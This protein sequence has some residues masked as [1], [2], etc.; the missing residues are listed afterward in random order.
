LALALT[1]LSVTIL[2][3]PVAQAATDTVTNCSGDLLVPG[4]LP[5]EVANADPG[6]TVAFSLSP[7][8]ATITPS[9]TIEL[10]EDLTI[11]GPGAGSLTVSGGGSI[12]VL[13]VDPGVTASISGLSIDNGIASGGGAIINQGSLMVTGSILSNDDASIGEGGAVYNVTG[14]T[15]SISDSTLSNDDASAGGGIFNDGATL[16]VTDSTLSNDDAS[17]GGGVYNDNGG[18]VSIT[19]STLAN[20]SAGQTGGGLDNDNFGVLTLTSSTLWADGADIEGGGFF[21]GEATMTIGSIIVAASPAGGDCSWNVA[22]TDEGDNLGDD[23]SCLFHAATDLFDTPAGLYPELEDNGGPTQTVALTTGS[24][25]IHQV[26]NG[27]LCPG[28][29]QRGAPR[30]VPCDIGAYEGSVAPPVVPVVSDVSPATGFTAGG[31]AVTVTGSGFTGATAVDFSGTPA[32]IDSV[33]GDTSIS[34]T[35]PVAS[36][37]G[38]VDV[39]VRGPEGES[40]VSPADQFT[41]TVDQTSPQSEPCTPTCATN[42]VTTALNNTSVSVT[43]TSGNNDPDATTNLTINS[44][45][46]DCGSSKAHDYDYVT[47]VSTVSTTDFAAHQV[48]TV[49]ESLGSEPSTKGVKVCYAPSSTATSG[50]FLAKCKASMKAPCLQTLAEQT[51]SVQATLLVP[52]GDPRFWTG[53]GALGL[54]SFSPPKGK[55]GTTVVAIKGKN[56]AQVRAVVI[57]GAQAAISGKSTDTKLLVTVPAGAAVRSGVISVTSAAGEAV[58]T[59]TF[60]VT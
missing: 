26:H 21:N 13:A 46:L 18:T 37:A 2:P 10:S 6:D 27:S 60:T 41:Y 33:T 34:V 45:T 53:G 36:S 9:S 44:D 7:P 14:A 54:T 43:G 56:L 32:V 29:D 55:P 25:A 39:T 8:C 23:P 38:T 40:S 35:A 20:D 47:A 19:N 22:P 28:T 52:A 24:A 17:E 58:S 5:Y 16:T 49:T 12:G 42:T 1:T 3:A 11:T 31:T 59:K 15:L 48:L 30:S 50:S 51:G 57:G 4:S